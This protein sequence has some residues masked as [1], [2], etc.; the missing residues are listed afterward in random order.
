MQSVTETTYRDM[1]A[2]DGRRVLHVRIDRHHDHTAITVVTPFDTTLD[3][4]MPDAEADA[5]LAFLAAEV[6]SGTRLWTLEQRAGAW[7]SAMAVADQAEQDLIDAVNASIDNT[8]TKQASEQPAVSVQPTNWHRLRSDIAEGSRRTRVKNQA[9][10]RR[11]RL[12]RTNVHTKPLTGPMLDLIRH[13][14][15]GVVTTRP[16]QSWTVLR[17]IYERVGGEPT[18]RPGTRIITSLRL[19]ERGMAIANNSEEIAA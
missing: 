18:Y 7:T 2:A 14:R 19:N 1:H 12:T 13:H 16:G 5:Y 17:G 3:R 9:L 4:A 15:G 8:L 10:G 11:I 6:E